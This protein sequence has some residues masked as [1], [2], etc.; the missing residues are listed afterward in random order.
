MLLKKRLVKNIDSMSEGIKDL[1]FGFLIHLLIYWYCKGWA[2]S[3]GSSQ[4]NCSF[5][6]IANPK[7]VKLWYIAPTIMVNII[8]N[9][10]VPISTNKGDIWINILNNFF[11]HVKKPQ[12][13]ILFTNKVFNNLFSIKRQSRIIN[14]FICSC[15][16]NLF[17]WLDTLFCQSDIVIFSEL[18]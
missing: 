14:N 16:Y 2:I 18:S 15:C 13:I 11:F 5:S 10:H 3:L 6:F 17:C 1:L 8:L 9:F 4:K 7:K 12:T